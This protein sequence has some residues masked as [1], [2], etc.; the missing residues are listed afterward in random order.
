M[1]GSLKEERLAAAGLGSVRSGEEAVDLL[2]HRGS[3]DLLQ[4]LDGSVAQLLD[5]WKLLQ[6]KWSLDFANPGDLLHSLNKGRLG[7]RTPL[8]P[9]ERVPAGLPGLLL[10]LNGK[11][12][13]KA[14]GRLLVDSFCKN[15]R[16]WLPYAHICT[17]GARG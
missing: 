16:P 17:V 6:Q 15:V 2:C 3:H 14:H 5:R 10:N 4:F 1:V 9:E 7:E 8:L 13:G 12:K 11:I